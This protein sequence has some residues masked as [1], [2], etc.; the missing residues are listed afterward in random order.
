VIRTVFALFAVLLVA[1]CALL[2]DPLESR[3]LYR[4]WPANADRLASFSKGM[5]NVEDVT[6]TT[7]DGATLRGWLQKPAGAQKFPLVIVF[8]SAVREVSSLLLQQKSPEWGWLLVNYRGFGLSEGRPNEDAVSS[9][10][11]LIFD[12]AINRTDVEATRIVVLGRSIGSAVA[13]SLAAERPLAGVILGTPFAT[14]A[15]VADLRYPGISLVVGS[16]YDSASRAP[17]V[18]YPA[19]FLIA[20]NDQVTP[21]DSGERL[22]KVWGGEARVVRI[23]G[24][25]HYSAE[26]FQE[27]WSEIGAFLATIGAAPQ[28]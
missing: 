9:D 17:R 27:Y 2:R 3:L 25:S 28:R 13:I 8:G 11:K 22:A 18:R 20:G 14:L 6:L 12:Y 1:G 7:A 26:R 5:P 24:A 16:R 10:A 21:P 19:L 23:P 4:P 15:E